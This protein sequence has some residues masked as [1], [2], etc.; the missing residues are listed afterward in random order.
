MLIG[1]GGTD[2]ILDE[3]CSTIC[4]T[5]KL[6]PLVVNVGNY[7][8]FPLK[9][10]CLPVYLFVSPLLLIGMFI[11]VDTQVGEFYGVSPGVSPRNSP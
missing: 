11:P 10:A 8:V 4:A 5:F 9:S 1:I 3:V 6:L 2:H 7:L